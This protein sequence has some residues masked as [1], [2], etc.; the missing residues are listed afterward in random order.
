MKPVVAMF[1]EKRWRIEVCTWTKCIFCQSDTDEKLLKATPE[2]T[3]PVKVV[4]TE[5]KSL[6][7]QK[8]A[9][10]LERLEPDITTLPER[11]ASWH[12]KCYSAFTNKAYIDHIRKHKE[13]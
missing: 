2:G 11:S 13:C 7:D 8:N 6:S 3:E 12:K 4:H 1:A 10:L 9:W 5:R